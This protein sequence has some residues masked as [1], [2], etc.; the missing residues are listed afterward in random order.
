MNWS[1][2]LAALALVLVLEGIVPVVS[3]QNIKK[4]FALILQMDDKVLR[5]FGFISIA[6]G[7]L[8]LYFVRG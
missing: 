5:I 4:T 7:L 8:L 6:A 2:L 3:P 1:D